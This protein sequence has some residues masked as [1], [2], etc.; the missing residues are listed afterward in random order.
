MT[1]RRVTG[2]RRGRKLELELLPIGNGQWLDRPAAEAFLAMY[3]HA[4]RDGIKL[5]A[6]SGHREHEHQKK[7]RA[8]YE[9]LL[10]IWKLTPPSE[11]GPEPRVAAPAG[12][13]DHEAGDAVD[14]NRASGDDPRTQEPDSP[15]DKWLAAHA[16]KYGFL[17]TVRSE[18]WHF[19]HRPEAF[20]GTGLSMIV[21]AGGSPLVT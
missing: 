10:D 6:N 11:R 14:I 20:A 21:P 5:A 17:R 7:L 2:Y 3:E 4:L 9:R 13:S 8:D 19:A 18:P 1:S 16:W 12:W 15:I